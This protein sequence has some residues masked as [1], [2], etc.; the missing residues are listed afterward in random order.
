MRWPSSA[1]SV[2]SSVN[3]LVTVV[4]LGFLFIFAN[5]IAAR[6]YTRI[7]LT[8]T[9]ITQLAPQTRQALAGLQAPLSVVVFY[10][11]SHRL[12][13]LVRDMLEEYQRLSPHVKLELV[14]PEQDLA[15]ANQLAKQFQIEALNVV[16]FS[17]ETRHKH[18]SDTDLA[19][20]DT[21]TARFGGEPRVKAFKGEEAFTAALASVTQTTTPLIW[22]VTGHGEKAAEDETPQGL[23]DVKRYLEQQNMQVTEV[24]LL[25]QAAIPAEVKLILIAGP[26][27]RFTDQEVTLLNAYLQAGGRVLALLD[28]LQDTDLETLCQAWGITLGHDIVVDPARQ[29]P[30]VSAANLFVTTYS[31]HPIVNKMATLMTLFPLARSVTPTAPAPAGYTTTALALTSEKG[32]GESQTTVETFAFDA[33]QDLKGPVVIAAA[34]EQTAEP[35]GRLV[36]IGD[37]DFAINAQVGNVGN[38]D[39]LM[40]AVYWLTAQEQRIGISP[41]TLESLKL[42]LTAR[43]MTGVF[44]FSFL[45]LPLTCALLGLVMWWTRR[46]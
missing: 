12:Y 38:R 8:Q 1:R 17:A 10:Q 29:L 40:G 22:T 32:W 45:V 24:T 18:V 41:R 36:V 6:R 4:L 42:S 43:Q 35:K 30:F 33:A 16:V 28:P 44:W 13:E 23:S 15:R 2:L 7:D 34:A 9:K 11:P 37:S 26:T 20:F 46:N 14:D 5:F 25:E 39:F 3:F 19:E 31:E 21:S 27:R